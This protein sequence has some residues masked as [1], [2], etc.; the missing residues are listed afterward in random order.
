MPL[1]SLWKNFVESGKIEYYIQYKSLQ[2]K[3]ENNAIDN[4]SL[5]NK[6]NGCR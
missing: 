5:G 6:D 3:E 2:K 4:R 1:E